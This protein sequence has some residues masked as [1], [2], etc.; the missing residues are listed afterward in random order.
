MSRIFGGRILPRVRESLGSVEYGKLTNPQRAELCASEYMNNRKQYDS[1]SGETPQTTF[2]RD[3]LRQVIEALQD[4]GLLVKEVEGDEAL[5]WKSGD[6]TRILLLKEP[7]TT[8]ADLFSLQ[9]VA[10][11]S[12]RMRVAGKAAK[13]PTV[14]ELRMRIRALFRRLF[15][16]V[17]ST[18]EGNAAWRYGIAKKVKE[19]DDIPKQ[20]A[21]SETTRL[22]HEE[23]LAQNWSCRHYVGWCG[24]KKHVAKEIVPAIFVDHLRFEESLIK[25]LREKAES[26]TKA[27]RDQVWKHSAELQKRLETAGIIFGLGASQGNAANAG[28]GAEG[29]SDD[30]PDEV[31][32]DAD[33]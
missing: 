29:E 23:M 17:T 1:S 7:N 5:H 3:V 6:E 32:S 27:A 19:T 30:D 24:R 10:E 15:W 2:R 8:A 16:Q 28:D 31:K 20:L 25:D 14:D 26:A 18:D 22:F 9:Q 4:R 21:E 33:L 11:E 12:A 13:D